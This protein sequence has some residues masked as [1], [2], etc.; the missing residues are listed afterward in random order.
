M[1][2]VPGKGAAP[3]DF[4]TTTACHPD[5]PRGLA[6]GRRG[7]QHGAVPFDV[8]RL[9]ALWTTPFP[10]DRAAEAA[11][12]EVYADPVV[13]NGVPVPAAGL[14]ARARALQGV[15]ESAERQVLDVVDT[16]GK[17]AVAFRLSGQQVGVLAT[18][19]GPLQPTGRVVAL[20]VI[21]VLTIT[22]G[23]ISDIWMVADELGALVAVDAVRLAQPVP[24]D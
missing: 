13:V 23:R 10:D 15:F 2:V 18:A 14:V 22:D 16:G 4:P 20:R 6:R 21:D 19:A 1:D 11:F 7:G 5:A 9:L 12:R 3:Q 24:E 17:V 8:D